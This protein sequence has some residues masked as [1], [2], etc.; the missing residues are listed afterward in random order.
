MTKNLASH[1]RPV[2]DGVCLGGLS[3]SDITSD[4]PPYL[5]GGANRQP[6]CGGE[7]TSYREAAGFYVSKG[8][9]QTEGAPGNHRGNSLKSPLAS[10]VEEE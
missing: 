5:P 7:N 6:S 1:R 9:A 2:T 3:R 4:V 8:P 10:L